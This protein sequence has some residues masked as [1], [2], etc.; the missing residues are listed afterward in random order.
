MNR[1]GN[2][3]QPANWIDMSFDLKAAREELRANESIMTPYER[4]VILHS[5]EE[6]K[7]RYYP[8]ILKG[9]TDQVNRFIG[10]YKDVKAKIAQEHAREIARWDTG[11]LN[12]EMQ[13]YQMFVNQAIDAASMS[14]TGFTKGPDAAE[15]IQ[16][17]WA[18]AKA[19]GDIYKQRALTE[20]LTAASGRFGAIPKESASRVSVLAK[21][22][23]A[24]LA[25]IRETE[26]IRAARDEERKVVEG[27]MIARDAA[28]DVGQNV[29]GEDTRGVFA[30]GEFTKAGK[31]IQVDQFGEIKIYEPDDPEIIGF[32]WKRL[33]NEVEMKG[34][35]DE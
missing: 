19:S 5:I 16:G 31:R 17:L 1:Y 24:N 27:L 26:G 11:R 9:V 29:M 30:S 8:T 35:E 18:E 3:Q 13:A 12:A 25:A 14:N 15:R 2:A 6:K 23:Q 22:A 20:I 32:D 7:E 4:S 28:Y 10:E 33:Q 34:G 21:E